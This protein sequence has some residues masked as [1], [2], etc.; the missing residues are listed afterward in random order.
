MANY[1]TEQKISQKILNS[2]IKPL[3]IKTNLSAEIKISVKAS[4][5]LHWIQSKLI[6]LKNEFCW[7]N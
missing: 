5:N 1:L 6:I 3:V 2:I 4:E 7:V